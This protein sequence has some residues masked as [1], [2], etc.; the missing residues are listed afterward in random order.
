M[1]KIMNE[2]YYMVDDWADQQFRDK[3]KAKSLEE[4]K[5]A[6][7]EEIIRRIGDEGREMLEALAGLSMELEDIHDKALFQA[8]FSLG[9]EA[10][11]PLRA[12]RAA[13]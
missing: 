4:Q 8:S 13:G 9:T 1:T 12:P 3:E 2:L 10:V 7:E 11:R 5:F 6:L